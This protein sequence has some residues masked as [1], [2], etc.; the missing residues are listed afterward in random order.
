M[1]D[2]LFGKNCMICG[3]IVYDDFYVC[4]YC[5]NSIFQFTVTQDEI[6]DELTEYYKIHGYD[7]EEDK[8]DLISRL[9]MKIKVK[10]YIEKCSLQ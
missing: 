5:I 10:K 4:N 3:G 9:S 7:K 1:F 8:N 2:D 6:V